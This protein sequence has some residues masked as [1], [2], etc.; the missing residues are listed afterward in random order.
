MQCLLS[1]GPTLSSL[2]CIGANIR[3]RQEIKFVGCTTT[4]TTTPVPQR[5]NIRHYFIY[6]FVYIFFQGV[7]FGLMLLIT[8][9]NFKKI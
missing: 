9:G 2:Y 4:N 7:F 8:K 3:A 6:I 5:L 1:T